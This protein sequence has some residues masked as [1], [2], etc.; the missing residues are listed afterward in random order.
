M[1]VDS[2]IDIL[3]FHLDNSEDT[4]ELKPWDIEKLVEYLE[5]YKELKKNMEDDLK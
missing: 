4:I 3:K 2:F 1:T 5:E